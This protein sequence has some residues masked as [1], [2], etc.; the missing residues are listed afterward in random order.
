[1]NRLGLILLNRSA[2][3]EHASHNNISTA[4]EL[5]VVSKRLEAG[6]IAKSLSLGESWSQMLRE[7]SG[8]S[9][10]VIVNRKDGTPPKSSAAK[11][12]ARL[13]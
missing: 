4:I 1:M 12:R 2:R 10:A 13:Q 11:R 6:W 7:L 3:H 8:L 5:K 9:A